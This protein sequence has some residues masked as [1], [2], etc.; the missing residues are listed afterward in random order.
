MEEYLKLVLCN[1]DKAIC[2]L[3]PLILLPTEA[4]LVL[5]EGCGKKNLVKAFNSNSDKIIFTLLIKVEIF[6][7]GFS[8]VHIQEV[9][10][11]MFVL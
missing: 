7:M 8:A 2:V 6:Y 3:F 11:Q 4:N 9:S 1:W 10:F 5:K